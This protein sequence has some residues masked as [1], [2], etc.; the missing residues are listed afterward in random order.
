MKSAPGINENNLKKGKTVI[1]SSLGG[2]SLKISAKEEV[3]E[4][5]VRPEGGK[6]THH[7]ENRHERGAHGRG[8]TLL[9]GPGCVIYPPRR[10]RKQRG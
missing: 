4:T 5:A 7:K 3:L 9:R 10:T 8:A 1:Q 6:L 2:G